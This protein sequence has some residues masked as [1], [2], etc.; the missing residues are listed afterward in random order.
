MQEGA[1]INTHE[2]SPYILASNNI[3]LETSPNFSNLTEFKLNANNDSK[4]ENIIECM[5]QLHLNKGRGF[6]IY[7]ASDLLLL[8]SNKEYNNFLLTQYGFAK[9]PLGKTL[10]EISEKNKNSSHYSL[11][12]KVIETGNPICINKFELTNYANNKIFLDISLIPIY[13]N[14]MLKYV[15][16]S[17][18]DVTEL[19]N[20]ENKILYYQQQEEFFSFICH[21][22]KTPLTVTLS[23]I[24]AIKLICKDDLSPTSLKYLKKMQQGSLQ[25]WRLVTH[26]LD[27]IKSGSGYLQVHKKNLDIVKMTKAIIDGVSEYAFTKGINIIFS[28]SVHEQIIGIDDEKYERILLNLLSN[29]IKY[30]PKGNSIYVSILL[31][32]NMVKIT[33]KDTG[34]GIPNEKID[35]IFQPF[36]QI[37]NS[38]TRENEGTGIGLYLVKQL[39]T[40]LCGQINV[41]SIPNVGSSFTISLPTELTEEENKEPIYTFNDNRLI[42]ITNIEFSDI[43][44]D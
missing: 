31:E 34:I 11:F 30:T 23:A 17:F 14:N 8:K 20:K 19:K 28:T 1:Y 33:V 32:D 9:S 25:Q 13:E 22:F 42:E 43:Y 36:S 18:T 5:E 15:I 7:C 16:E 39:V 37:D 24:Q 6:G 40:T 2:I 38:L 44:F 29:A 4:F 10:D 3:L 27:I 35:T 41:V 21:E 12:A 26:L